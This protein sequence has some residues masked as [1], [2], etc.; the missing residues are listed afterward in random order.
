M[1]TISSQKTLW[2][3]LTLLITIVIILVSIFSLKSG[4]YDIFP[5]FYIIPIILLAYLFP[6]YSVYFTI[7]I[8]WIFLGLVYLY[9]PVDIRLYAASSAFFYI[10][11][12]AGIVI[13]AFAGQLMQGI[14]AARNLT[15]S[16][17]IRPRALMI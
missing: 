9:G 4:Y 13:S 16:Y 17:P 5:F 14:E 1:K 15:K 11:V 8:G 7:F 3:S 10:F 12:S 6:R 2:L